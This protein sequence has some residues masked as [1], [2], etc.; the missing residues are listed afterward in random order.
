MDAEALVL[1]AVA[2]IS[3]VA[4]QDLEIQAEAVDLFFVQNFDLMDLDFD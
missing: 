1:V 2:L 4:M 3:L